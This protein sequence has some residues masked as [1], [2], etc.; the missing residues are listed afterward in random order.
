MW[1]PWNLQ[2]R[3]PP[4]G[5]SARALPPKLL[6][7]EKRSVRVLLLGPRHVRTAHEMPSVQR[8]A[9]LGGV[10]ARSWTRVPRK[11]RQCVRSEATKAR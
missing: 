6:P 3:G 11:V 2:R 4:K 7:E 8:S 10:P 9:V 1:A 5:R